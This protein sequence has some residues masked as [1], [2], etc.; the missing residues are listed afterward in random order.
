MNAKTATFFLLITTRRWIYGRQRIFLYKRFA[1]FAFI[2]S[3]SRELTSYSGVTLGLKGL[4][5]VSVLE[6]NANVR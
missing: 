6:Y 3:Y 5:W 4:S 1:L 2:S